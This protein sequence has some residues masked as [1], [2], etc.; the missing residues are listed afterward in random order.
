MEPLDNNAK[1]IV[2]S[3][4]MPLQ[5]LECS[6]V[7]FSNALLNQIRRAVGITGIFFLEGALSKPDL[8]TYNPHHPVYILHIIR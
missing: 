3:N 4:L 2:K 7:S 1:I 5:D 6:C 8:T